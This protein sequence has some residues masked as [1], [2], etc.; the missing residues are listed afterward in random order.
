[1]SLPFDFPNLL[2]LDYSKT[3]VP[4]LTTDMQK[5]YSTL[6]PSAKKWW[7]TF[8]PSLQTVDS[9]PQTDDTCPIFH[10]QN[11]LQRPSSDTGEETAE[12]PTQLLDLRKKSWNHWKR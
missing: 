10:L 9:Q 8:L 7:E 4:N 6:T 2:P 5:W 1:M 12:I 11:H 3:D